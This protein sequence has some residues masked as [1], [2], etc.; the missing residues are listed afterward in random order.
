MTEIPR[1]ARLRQR[2]CFGS[3]RDGAWGAGAGQPSASS[4]W[5][6]SGVCL[7]LRESHENDAGWCS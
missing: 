6:V 3:R 7:K 5:S 4:G 2:G 1:A